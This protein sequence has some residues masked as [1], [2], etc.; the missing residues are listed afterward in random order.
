MHYDAT[1]IEYKATRRTGKME[2]IDWQLSPVHVFSQR[3]LIYWIQYLLLTA[4]A[5]EV[6]QSPPS[7]S[8][9]TFEPSDL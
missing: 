4:L 6:M 1:D 2:A 3:E 5:W 8:I 9:L 7:V